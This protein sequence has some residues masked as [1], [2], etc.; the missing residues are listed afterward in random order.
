MFLRGRA[1]ECFF[2]HSAQ[3]VDIV[4]PCR[5]GKTDLGLW[6]LQQGWSAAGDLAT[7]DYREAEHA[8]RCGVIGIWRGETPPRDCS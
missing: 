6:L 2:P 8:A 4:A 5:V 1:V 3:V 7:V